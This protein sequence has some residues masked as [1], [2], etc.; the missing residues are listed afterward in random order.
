MRSSCTS[1][2]YSMKAGSRDATHPGRHGG[3]GEDVNRGVDLWRRKTVRRTLRF[4]RRLRLLRVE[5]D[6][7]HRRRLRLRPRDHDHRSG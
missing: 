7:G 5:D 1:M 4:C 2:T 6:L 3:V